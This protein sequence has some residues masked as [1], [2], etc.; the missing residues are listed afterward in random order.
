MSY[1]L[2][3]LTEIP[4]VMTVSQLSKFLGIGRNQGYQLVRSNQLEVLR[5]G[6]QIRIPRH[7]VLRYLGVSEMQQTAC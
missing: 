4:P 5:I 3:T 2:Y 1:N 7:S 6:K